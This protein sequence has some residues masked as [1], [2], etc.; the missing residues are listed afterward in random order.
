M[1]GNIASSKLVDHTSSLCSIRKY[2]N[3]LQRGL[4]TEGTGYRGD[5]LQ[6][7][8]VTE[9]TGYRGDWLQR[10]LVTEGTGYRGDWLQRGLVTEG[11]GYRGDWLQRGLAMCDQPFW[12]VQLK[13]SPYLVRSL[14]H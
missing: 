9:G 3:W 10:G 5:W 12:E 11:T 7:G 13:M 6:R 8:L 14:L 1:R 4:V 2:T